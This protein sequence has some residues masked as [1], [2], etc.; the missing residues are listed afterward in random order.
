[1]GDVMETVQDLIEKLKEFPPETPVRRQMTA[2]YG[3]VEIEKV[4]I[5][6]GKVVID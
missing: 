1:M 2:E 5:R 6:N 4:E 3:T